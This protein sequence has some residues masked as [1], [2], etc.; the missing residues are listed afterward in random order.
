MEYANIDRDIESEELLQIAKDNIKLKRNF[1]RHL[2]VFAVALAFIPIVSRLGYGH[3]YVPPQ[4]Q[5]SDQGIA[6]ALA[7]LRLMMDTLPKGAMMPC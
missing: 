4:I 7:E 2:V 1:I 6:A 3:M 5:L